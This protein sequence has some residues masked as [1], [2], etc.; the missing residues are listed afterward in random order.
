MLSKEV[1]NGLEVAAAIVAVEEEGLP[2]WDRV[3]EENRLDKDLNAARL[4]KQKEDL[5]KRISGDT[6][7]DCEVRQGALWC[8][9]RLVVP[10]SMIT[11]VIQQVHKSRETGHTGRAKT[12][13]AIEN[14]KYFIPKAV[15]LVRKFLR[16]C[17]ICRRAKPVHQLPAGFL[18][19]L[20][21]PDRPW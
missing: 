7:S 9:E 18:Q 11:E 8:K 20:P 4:E 16:N 19:P 2:L 3:E 1:K 14:S 17:H 21:I 15:D 10:P 6:I 5:E 13:K 12:M